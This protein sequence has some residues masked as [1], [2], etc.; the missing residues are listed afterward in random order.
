MFRVAVVPAFMSPVSPT[1]VTPGP[2]S[3]MRSFSPSNDTMG[4]SPAGVSVRRTTNSLVTAKVTGPSAAVAEDR[5]MYISFG[6]VS[7]RPTVTAPGAADGGADGAAD[8]DG[9]GKGA[10]VVGPP[11]PD[12]LHAGRNM[13]RPA[14]AKSAVRDV[15]WPQGPSERSVD[16]VIEPPRDG[17]GNCTRLGP[18]G[19]GRSAHPTRSLRTYAGRDDARRGTTEATRRIE[20][21]HRRPPAQSP[22]PRHPWPRRRMG[23]PPCSSP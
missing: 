15:R 4:R 14:S 5:W 1:L 7:P 20:A 9:L 17:C 19:T 8:G 23:S 22:A 18:G 11:C 21:C 3:S 10:S 12:E 13:A 2:S 6:E 16:A